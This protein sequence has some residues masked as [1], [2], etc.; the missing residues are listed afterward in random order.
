LKLLADGVLELSCAVGVADTNLAFGLPTGAEGQGIENAP[1][2]LRAE[3]TRSQGSC[4]AGSSFTNRGGSYATTAKV[5]DP[6]PSLPS[7]ACHEAAHLQTES[8]A[9]LE[10]PGK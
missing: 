8:P 9:A 4:L 5:P 10:Q 2:S 7:V 6:L 3:V 1:C